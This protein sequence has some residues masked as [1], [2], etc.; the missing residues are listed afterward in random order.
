MHINS[1][2]I[3]RDVFIG[4]ESSLNLRRCHRMDY[5]RSVEPVSHKYRIINRRGLWMNKFGF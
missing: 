1:Q 4:H 2:M 3:Y 5:R